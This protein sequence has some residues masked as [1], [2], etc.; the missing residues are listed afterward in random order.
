M[1]ILVLTFYY[2]PDLCAGSFRTTSLVK[3]LKKRLQDNDTLDII[4]TMPN[5]YNSF[6]DNALEFEEDSNIKIYRINLGSHKSGFLDQMLLFRKFAFN[7]AN[8]IWKNEKYDIVYATSSRLMTAFLG[9]LIANNQKSKLF[10]DLRDI[11]TDTLESLFAKS[12]L[13]YIIPMFKIIEKYT[14][15]SAQHINLVSQGFEKYFTNINEKIDYSFYSNGIDDEFLHFDFTKEKQTT[16][17][18]ITYAG[19]IGEGQGLDKI[20]PQM[21]KMLGAD[22]IIQIIGDGG[23]RLKLVEALQGIS[24][25]EILPPVNRTTLLEI[26]KNSDYLFLHLNDYDAFKKVLP[27]KIFEY[28]ATHKVIIAGV[29]GYARDFIETNLRDAIVFEPC[30]AHD[31]IKNFNAKSHQK[32]SDRQEFIQHYSR[33]SIMN[34]LSKKVYEL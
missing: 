10:L 31:F 21:A 9:A 15:N 12:R 17:K 24:N 27:S 26:Y 7:V 22:Y 28:A 1:R 14:V 33:E 6:Y 11:F 16:K 13:K 8:I 30:N 4:T 18:I 32:I 34:G 25:V 29:G 3:A 20:I 23:T 19:N 2:Q 5:R